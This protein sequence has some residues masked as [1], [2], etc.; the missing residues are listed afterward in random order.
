MALLGD[1]NAWSAYYN[2]S[3]QAL[4]NE[5]GHEDIINASPH[6]ILGKGNGRSCGNDIAY[7]P[8]YV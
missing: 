8:V 2:F 6:A 5:V 3:S 7:T 1:G 4:E